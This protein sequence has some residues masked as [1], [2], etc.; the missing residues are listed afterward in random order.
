MQ[1]CAEVRAVLL[2]FKCQICTCL[3]RKRLVTFAVCY[4]CLPYLPADTLHLELGRSPPGV[5]SL[6]QQPVSELGT[7]LLKDVQLY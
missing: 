5:G 4:L 2:F 3:D 6:I 1:S 7:E